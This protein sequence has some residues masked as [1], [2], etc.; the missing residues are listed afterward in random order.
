MIFKQISLCEHYA[1]SQTSTALAYLHAQSCVTLYNPTDCKLTGSSAHG[2]S[3]ARILEWVAI[4]F[5]SGSSKPRDWTLAWK[6]PWTEEPG[7]LQSMGS[8]RVGHDWGISLSLF[9]SM[10][11]R[12]KWQPTP[13]FLPGESQRQGSLVEGWIWLKRLSSSSCIS[14]IGRWIPYH[15]ATW[16]VLWCWDWESNHVS[17]LPAEVC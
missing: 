12:R 2:I 14:Y 6:I 3:Q 8:L 11:W 10:H 5:S 9:T 15:W 17:V 7:G 16:E 4:S 13:V 1:L